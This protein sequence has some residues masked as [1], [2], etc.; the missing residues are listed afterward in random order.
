MKWVAVYVNENRCA[1]YCNGFKDFS[2]LK[3][4]EHVGARPKCPR[5]GLEGI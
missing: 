4:A 1:L 3:K 2:A 5:I